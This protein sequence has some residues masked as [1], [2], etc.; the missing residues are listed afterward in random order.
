MSNVTLETILRGVALG[1]SLGYPLEFIG[2]PTKADFK[3]S[4]KASTLRV[5]DDTQM[6]M[7]L[8]EALFV[9]PGDINEEKLTNAYLRWLKTQDFDPQI[10]EAKINLLA[11]PEMFASR[12]PGRTCITS[13]TQLARRG[14]RVTNN[15]K[16][17]GTVMRCLPIAWL[18]FHGKD[19][20]HVVDI[21]AM[22]ARVTHD[23]LF[24]VQCSA[25]A[26][27]AGYYM[28]KGAD[29]KSAFG[30]ALMVVSI[31]LGLNPYVKDMISK[32]LHDRRWD[33][34]KLGG[35]VAEE[36]LAL[37]IAANVRS[38][39]FLEVIE[40]ASCIIGDS[41]TV[42]A[43]AGGLAALRGWEVPSHSH[44]IDVE[45]PLVWLVGACS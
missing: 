45:D 13:L 18:A 41:D 37:A 4:L 1:D 33:G 17:N 5:S 27:A 35:W 9:T 20:I 24:A 14:S 11:F 8:A 6:S 7:F 15:S 2:R 34:S 32:A 29:F 3:R 28:L 10:E 40:R 19:A 31:R 26:A 22:D 43:I 30:E 44:R 23:H 16:G 12:A 39:S 36:A 25:L 21:A 42:A 38:E